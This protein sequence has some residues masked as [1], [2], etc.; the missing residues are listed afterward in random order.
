MG[1]TFRLLIVLLSISLATAC[2]SRQVTYDPGPHCDNKAMQIP[3]DARFRTWRGQSVVDADAADKALAAMK[4]CGVYHRDVT[5]Q[6]LKERK[7]ECGL[8]CKAGW[9][10]AGAGTPALAE[11]FLFLKSAAIALL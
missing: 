11:L 9:A 10:G 8:Q 6:L 2:G 1:K 5:E 4:R 7:E 3:D